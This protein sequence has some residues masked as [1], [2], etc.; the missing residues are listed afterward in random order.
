VIELIN[1]Q[2]EAA[3]ALGD[4]ERAATHVEASVRGA[5]RLRSPKRLRDSEILYEQLGVRW[6][7]D[8]RVKR[9]DELI[10][11]EVPR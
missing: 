6:P 8:P 4:I 7:T 3:I 2:A 9:L 1:C 11:T 10:R 5:K